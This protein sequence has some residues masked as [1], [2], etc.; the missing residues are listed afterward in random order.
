[1]MLLVEGLHNVRL[2]LPIDNDEPTIEEIRD[3]SYRYLNEAV[4]A[5][6]RKKKIKE[7]G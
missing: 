3:V 6:L 7:K 1:M 2:S 4:P 5:S